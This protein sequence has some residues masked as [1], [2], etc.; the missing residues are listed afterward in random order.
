MS[1]P[2]QG[3]MDRHGPNVEIFTFFLLL[4]ERWDDRSESWF[5]TFCMLIRSQ[6]LRL[7]F[8]TLVTAKDKVT[9]VCRLFC[10]RD[11]I[12]GLRFP[13]FVAS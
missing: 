3:G 9:P 1:A 11:K 5:K 6:R 8:E 10:S 7:K 13:H 2:A 12:V 4:P